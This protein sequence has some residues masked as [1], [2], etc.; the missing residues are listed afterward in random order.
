VLS[1]FAAF[2]V[3]VGADDQYVSFVWRENAGYGAVT[4]NPVD[5][6]NSINP[7]GNFNYQAS[8]NIYFQ[9]HGANLNPGAPNIGARLRSRVDNAV[10][11]AGTVTLRSANMLTVR[12]SLALNA[13]PFPAGLYDLELTRNTT[14]NPCPVFV[15]PEAVTIVDNLLSDPTFQ[16]NI[17][18]NAGTVQWN[19]GLNFS[20]LPLVWHTNNVTTFPQNG[21]EWECVKRG[22]KFHPYQEPPRETRLECPRQG[23]FPTGALETNGPGDN[24]WA[25]IRWDPANG[26]GQGRHQFWQFIDT[27]LPE[28]SFATLSGVWLGGTTSPST[29]NYGFEI[30][31]VDENG[32][33]LA[34]ATG[35]TIDLFDWTAF[36]YTL[37][38]PGGPHRLAFILYGDNSHDT[39]AGLHI[40]NL[41]LRVGARLWPD[42]DNDG[43]VDLD[44][45][46]QWQLAY[47]GDGGTIDPAA[48]ALDRDGDAD[49]DESDFNAWKACETRANV[50][51]NAAA[52]P[53]GCD[54]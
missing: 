28:T 10:T 41:L 9:V 5:A 31:D 29:L 11:I 21:N 36:S 33:I 39:D 24:E 23:D 47:T 32:T 12:V 34:Q 51:L 54:L 7:S 22:D 17:L 4:Q 19:V 43:D 53:P 40:D 2:P 35:Q 30:R 50:P 38:L 48:A 1:P 25:T 44:D 49:L 52:I 6:N 14:P 20:W 16:T 13:T 42:I 37:T 46:S 8:G 45:F 27:N 18:G 15:L 3:P 26:I